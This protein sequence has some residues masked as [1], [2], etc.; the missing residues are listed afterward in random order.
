MRHLFTRSERFLS[1]SSIAKRAGTSRTR[2]TAPERRSRSCVERP[3]DP[4][5]CLSGLSRESS[6]G[7]IRQRGVD[8]PVAGD[9]PHFPA[10]SINASVPISDSISDFPRFPPRRNRGLRKLLC[11]SPAVQKARS[12]AG[13]TCGLCKSLLWSCYKEAT[14]MMSIV[15]CKGRRAG[16]RRPYYR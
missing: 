5:P 3:S 8:V 9:R 12:A 6:R 4:H 11:A 2:V 10:T 16:C 15:K 14:S 1:K 13:Q 7:Q